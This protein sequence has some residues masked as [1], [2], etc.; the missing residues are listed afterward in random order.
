MKKV[1]YIDMDGVLADFDS[2]LA[3]VPEDTRSEYEWPE[4]IPGVFALMDP[5]DGALDAYHKLAELFDTYV[6]STAPWNN[7]SAWS[8]K[9]QWVQKHLGVV[10]EKRLILT[11][12]KNLNKGDYLVDDR[13]RHGTDLFEG[14]HIH[15]GTPEF[16]DWPAVVAYLKQH[17]PDPEPRP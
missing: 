3:R 6:L 4:D 10:A 7:P 16:P 5:M 12:H 11:H 8:D 2:G 15:F 13:L 9:L 17:G 14:E 1:L